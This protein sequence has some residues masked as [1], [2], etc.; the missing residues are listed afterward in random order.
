MLRHGS[1]RVEALGESSGHCECC[2]NESRCVWGLVYTADVAAAAYWMHWTPGHL[3]EQGANLD[4]VIGR[5]GDKTVPE[6]RVAISLLHRQQVGG[7]PALMVIDSAERPIAFGGLAAKAARRNE[8]IGTP[9]SDYVFA[10][11]DAIYEHDK[12]FF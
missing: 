11:T 1:F 3:D 10:L 7:T 5:W 6:D 2:G 8:V 4:L 12:R 9:L